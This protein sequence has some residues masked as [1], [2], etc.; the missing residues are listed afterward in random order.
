[1]IT[2]AA[3]LSKSA[4]MYMYNRI[5]SKDIFSFNYYTYKEPF[6]GSFNGMRYKISRE[7]KDE[8]DVCFKVITW[9]EPYCEEKTAD[10]LKKY[11]E[12]EFTEDGKE[13]IV[14]YLNDVWR[15]DY[16]T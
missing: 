10:E 3:V 8:G 14:D 16:F 11:A 13:E 7:E 12:F 9:P 5:D 2:S 1:M 6:T 15:Q 4:M